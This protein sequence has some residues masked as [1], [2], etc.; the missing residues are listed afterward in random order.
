MRS[1]PTA[2]AA[3]VRPLLRSPKSTSVRPLGFADHVLGVVPNGLN[4]SQTAPD[5]IRVPCTRVGIFMNYHERWTQSIIDQAWS[6][7]RAY[8]HIYRKRSREDRDVQLLCLHCDPDLKDTSHSAVYKTGPHL[9]IRGGEPALDKAHLAICVN[10]ADLGGT[11]IS[12]LTETLRS[13]V[14]L[15]E[16]E[17]LPYYGSPI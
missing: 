1:R 6:L 12:T 15:I 10:D 16:L 7:D 8:L 14:R 5:Q 11:N 13:A 2:I 17:I 3:L 9:H 4:P